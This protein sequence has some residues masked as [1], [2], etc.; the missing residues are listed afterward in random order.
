MVFLSVA[1]PAQ[2]PPAPPPQEATAQEIS[3]FEGQTVVEIRILADGGE[4][5]SENPT[6]LAQKAGEPYDT[7]N[8]RKAL[9]QLYASGDYSNVVAEAS[10]SSNGLRMDFVVTRNFFIGV[11]VIDGLKEPPNEST[12]YAALRLR[13]GD[14]YNKAALDDSLQSLKQALALDG[15]YQGEVRADLH[16]DPTHRQMDLSVHVIPGPRALSG[17]ITLKNSTPYTDR[18]LLSKAKI[19]PKQQ[20]DSKKLQHAEDRVRD[21]L[22]KQDYLGA[23]ASIH[24]GTYNAS[25][26]TLPLELDVEAGP[27]VRVVIAGAKIP[28]KE[29]KRRVPVFEEGAVD[30]DLLAE[31]RRSLRDYFE[32]QG[33]FSATVEY[34]TS[35][36]EASG[37]GAAKQPEQVITY[38]VNRGPR[39]KFVGVT[40]E[41]NRYF[42]SDI[43]KGRLAIQPASFGSPGRFSQRLLDADIDSIRELYMANGFRSAVATSQLE[44]DYHGKE[45]DLFVR[46]RIQEGEQTLVGSFQL[47]GNKAVKEKELMN[48]ISSTPGEPYSDFNVSTD[49]DNVLAQYYNEGFPDAHLTATSTDIPVAS[50]PLT[51]TPSPESAAPAGGHPATVIQPR[52][53]LVYHIEEGTQVRVSDI[54]ISGYD[55]TRRG[56]IAR[57]VQ[58]KAGGPLREGEV[59]D[60]QRLL[61]NLGIFS[62]VTIAPQNPDGADPQKALDVV[63]EEAKRYTLGYGGG[64]EVQRLGGTGSSAVGGAIDA[65]PRVIF[66]ITKDNL[67]GRADSLSLKVRASTL[68]YRGLASYNTQNYFGKPNLSLQFTLLADKSQEVTTFT[69]TRYEGTLQLTQKA[70]RSTTL[71]YRY[72]YRKVFVPAVS[73]KIASE[74]VPLYSQPTQVS[75][76]GVSWIREHRDNPTDATKGSYNT[77][78]FELAEKP[79]GSKSSFARFFFQNSTYYPFGTKL[80]FARSFQFGVQQALGDTLSADIPLPERFFGGGGNS[81]RGFSLNEAG[82]R[83]PDTGYP[84]GGE[85]LLVF[86]QELRFPMHLPKLGSKLGGALFYDAGNV[87]SSISAITLRTSPTTESQLNGNLSY[88]SHT[89]GIGLRYATPIGAIRLDLGYQLN[90][91]EFY[92]CTLAP[93]GGCATVPAL[94]RMPHFQFFFNLG[95]IF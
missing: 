27:R 36:A 90:P 5:L 21:Y 41:G 95:S 69:S 92:S 12:A 26:N 10:R 82:P 68:Q 44:Q 79:I 76:F 89:L 53:A 20:M 46:I 51:V 34:K 93:A 23:R 49:R 28:G 63:V 31:G 33:Y 25:T 58:V 62:R 4:T 22:V 84:I 2:A 59:I 35:E 19:K 9:R 87:F 71:L 64:I 17:V 1:L 73:L 8:V 65:S 67:T 70:S 38:E 66:E 42:N 55:R 57:E 45:G 48:V 60:T 16:P 74:L 11:V 6:D 86:Q 15:L 32:G 39:Q 7:E 75:E 54:L 40:F 18:D 14:P 37:P 43:L 61:Y 77:S 80:V 52:V 3:Q 50:S 88:F 78:D 29:L 47:E 91:A 30:P 81:L 94:S 24:R 83:D 85:A 56:V 72:T 13:V